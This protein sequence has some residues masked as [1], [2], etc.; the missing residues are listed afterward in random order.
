MGAQSSVKSILL[1][2]LVIIS[3]SSFLFKVVESTRS[4]NAVPVQACTN[5]G[6]CTEFT[7]HHCHPKSL[8]CFAHCING[9]CNC[10]D[11]C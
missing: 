2:V 9:F 10:T 6:H 3:S 1:L 11:S 7:L 5:Q 8:R 4:L